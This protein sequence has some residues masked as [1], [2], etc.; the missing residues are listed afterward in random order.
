MQIYAH[1]AWGIVWDSGQGRPLGGRHVLL[2]TKTSLLDTQSWGSG[3]G[4][5][6]CNRSS[7]V[8]LTSRTA[9]LSRCAANR[10]HTHGEGIYE[11]PARRGSFWLSHLEMPASFG[12]E[13]ELTKGAFSALYHP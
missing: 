6:L 8:C 2:P 4:F 7:H 10:L 1:P 9:D 5:A 13:R 11:S 12:L 3:V